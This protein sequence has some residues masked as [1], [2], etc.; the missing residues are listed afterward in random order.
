MSTTPLNSDPTLTL[1]CTPPRA[2]RG[3]L[4][5][6]RLKLERVEMGG[7]QITALLAPTGFGRT[8]QLG[9]WCRDALARGSLAF[10]YSVDDRDEPLRL[11]QGLAHCARSAC[12]KRGFS[13]AFMQWIAQRTD[14]QEALT[15][16]LAEVAELS[17]DVLLLFDDVEQMPSASRAQV[18]VYLLGNAPPNLHL[19][20]SARSSSALLASGALT[21][22]AVTRVTAS[23]LR[24]T[25]DETI[26]VLSAALGA[27]CNLEAGVRLHEITEGWPLGVQLAIGALNRGGDLES[28]LEA[29]TS[30]IQRYFLDAVVDRLSSDATQLLVRLSRCPLLHPQ[31]GAAV[32]GDDRFA[33]ELLRLQE[34]TPL[35]IRAEGA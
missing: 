10:W 31:L 32:L 3:F 23:D 5:R 19:A 18:L 6:E 20:L 1:K 16:W 11:V 7:S 28:L 15:G 27:R 2:I 34:E 24:F 9:R 25:L 21:L 8:S 30:D 14:P 22:A 33:G 26:A 4:D 35:L 29:A 13:E 12:G 17:V